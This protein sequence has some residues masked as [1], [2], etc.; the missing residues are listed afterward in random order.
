LLDRA[1]DKP[2]EPVQQLDITVALEVTWK[3]AKP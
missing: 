2:A 3:P 1:L